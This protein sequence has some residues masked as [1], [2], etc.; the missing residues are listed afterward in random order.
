MQKQGLT[1]ESF[2]LNFILSIMVDK[3]AFQA[4]IQ[5]VMN[6]M[7]TDRVCWRCQEDGRKIA[8]VYQLVT[9]TAYWNCSLT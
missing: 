8:A 9:E 4:Q 7:L 3:P 6:I 1:I 2:E 5:S